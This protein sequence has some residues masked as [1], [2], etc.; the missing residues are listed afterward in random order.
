MMF[1][2]KLNKS[3]F[4]KKQELVAQGPWKDEEESTSGSEEY[5]TP[6]EHGTPS[7]EEWVSLKNE[8]NK[9]AL[10]YFTAPSNSSLGAVNF[11]FHCISSVWYQVY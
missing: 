6:D 5:G 2:K 1:L 10:A 3:Y 4:C 11:T 8:W 9:S 7:F